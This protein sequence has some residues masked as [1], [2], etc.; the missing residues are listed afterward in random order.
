LLVFMSDN[1]PC[2]GSEPLDRFMAGLH[3]LKGTVYENG[4]R[5]P[6]FMRWPG[7]FKS[8]ARVDRLTAHID[9][10][11]T[12][13]QVCGLQPQAAVKLDGL[14]LLPL[15]RSPAAAWPD[16]TLFLQWDS[17]QEPRRGR[18][19][20]VLTEKWKLVQPCGMDL[21]Q[22]QHIRDRY[23][24]LCLLQGR[25]HRSIEGAPRHE[26]YDIST[27]PGETNDV[28]G[29]H[30]ELVDRMKQQYDRWFGEVCARW[31]QPDARKPGGRN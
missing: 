17:G 4:V 1:G 28:A 13:L 30:L 6:C 14:S 19:F 29:E 12:I 31:L 8:P 3:G 26:L 23:A 18:A 10:L 21:P 15:L 5:T 22:Q 20:T 11:P 7:G 27:D 16:R 2:S 9:L 24:E 25:G